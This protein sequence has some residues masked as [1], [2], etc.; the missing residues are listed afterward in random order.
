[1]VNRGYPDRNAI[2]VDV[3]KRRKTHK[4]YPRYFTLIVLPYNFSFKSA[5]K[6]IERT[7]PFD[8]STFPRIE[9][10]AAYVYSYEKKIGNIDDALLLFEIFKLALVEIIVLQIFVIG[11]RL[12]YFGYL[13]HKS[14]R[15]NALHADRPEFFETSANPH[16]SVACGKDGRVFTLV[17]YVVFSFSKFAVF[18]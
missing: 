10:L 12:H 15:I 4:V 3:G 1:M 5:R 17:S 18:Y 14:A 6:R 8:N 7:L 2:F 13:A 9:N 11:E 16:I